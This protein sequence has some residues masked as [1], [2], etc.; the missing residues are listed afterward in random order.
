MKPAWKRT[1]RSG[2]YVRGTGAVN[3]GVFHCL[4]ATATILVLSCGL[5]AQSTAQIQGTIQDASGSAVP[6]AIVTAT[7]TATGA[8]RTTTTETDG[9]Y[10]LTSLP[11]G[12]YR[13]DIA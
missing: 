3:A 12:P 13:L 4:S 2:S 5:R 6:R 11:I 1:L 9:T 10:V 7:Q 8:V